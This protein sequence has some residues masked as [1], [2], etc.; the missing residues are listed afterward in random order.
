MSR[1]KKLKFPVGKPG[2]KPKIYWPPCA[3]CGDE[4]GGCF[5]NGKTPYRADGA[6]WGYQGQLCKKC[7][8]TL[9]VRHRRAQCRLEKSE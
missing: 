7:S 6:K 9:Y 2:R 4:N 1:R 5:P 8:N 3:K